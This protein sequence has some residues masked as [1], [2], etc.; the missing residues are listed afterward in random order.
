MFFLLFHPGIF[1]RL[2]KGAKDF[3]L[4]LPTLTYISEMSRF[5]NGEV[6]SYLINLTTR[7]KHVLD[8]SED[9]DMGRAGF[10]RHPVHQKFTTHDEDKASRIEMFDI[11][12]KMAIYQETEISKT[13]PYYKSRLSWNCY[14]NLHHYL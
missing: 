7:M 5:N 2:V 4:I 9:L 10:C 6:N 13:K 8:L 14:V 12:S 3:D 1:Q 11:F